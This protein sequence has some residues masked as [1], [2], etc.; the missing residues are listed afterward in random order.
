MT[1]PTDPRAVVEFRV[2]ATQLKVGDLVNTA[3]GEGDWQQ[4][5]GVYT[6]TG[7]DPSQ[8]DLKNLVDQLAGR[9]VVVTLTDLVPVDGGIYFSAGT[10]LVA[11]DDESEDQTVADAVSADDGE[12]VYLYTR[13]EVVTVRAA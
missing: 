3:P 5:T 1:S 10:A 6:G 13:F 2:P 7:S 12:R 8:L 9:Y 11:G 4:V